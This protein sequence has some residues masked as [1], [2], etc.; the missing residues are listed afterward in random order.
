M[1]LMFLGEKQA[2]KYNRL[3]L[4]CWSEDVDRYFYEVKLEG[5]GLDPRYFQ[6]GGLTYE[7][8][9]STLILTKVDKNKPVKYSVFAKIRTGN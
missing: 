6:K 4:M 5:S 7:F 1:S 9:T 3:I 2:L 8:R